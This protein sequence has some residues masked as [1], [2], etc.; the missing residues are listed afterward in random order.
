MLGNKICK[1]KPL[2]IFSRMI[3]LKIL[4]C[5]ISVCKRGLVRDRW[6]Q[7]SLILFVLISLE[8]PFFRGLER[9]GIPY[10]Y[11]QREIWITSLFGR[12]GCIQLATVLKTFLFT[13]SSPIVIRLIDGICLL[14][15]N[16]WW[17]DLGTHVNTFGDSV[18]L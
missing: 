1:M 14:R 11:F 10:I 18:R 2:P 15:R 8:L 7:C 3:Y 9:E 17:W 13:H 5:T 12:E 4:Y 16:P 6:V